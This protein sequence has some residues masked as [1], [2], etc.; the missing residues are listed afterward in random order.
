MLTKRE[1]ALV[2]AGL[3]TGAAIWA[4]GIAIT[5]PRSYDQCILA[6]V[7]GQGDRASAYMARYCERNF[8]RPR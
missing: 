8:E 4:A 3:V 6:H 5:E 7:T 1:A 2:A